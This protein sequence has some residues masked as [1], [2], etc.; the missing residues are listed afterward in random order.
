[1]PSTGQRGGKSS[2]GRK[3]GWH[4]LGQVQETGILGI[5]TETAP[6]ISDWVTRPISWEGRSVGGCKLIHRRLFFSLQ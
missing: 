2:R 4:K 6:V 1:M 5:R 3:R